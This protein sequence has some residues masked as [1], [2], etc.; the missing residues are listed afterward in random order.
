MAHYKQSATLW[1]ILFAVFTLV[2]SVSSAGLTY[3]TIAIHHK[4]VPG[5]TRLMDAVRAGDAR[6]VSALLKEGVDVNKRNAGGVTALMLA[7]SKG[8]TRIA[9]LLLSAGARPDITDYD[10]TTA[11]DRAAQNNYKQLASMLTARS[12]KV[13]KS[14]HVDGY[15]F[16]DDAIVD[17]SHPEWFKHSFYNLPDDLDEAQANGKQGIML[18]MSTRRCSYCKVFLDRVLSDPDIKRRVQSNYDVIGLEILSDLE[19]V[20]VDG[21]SYRVKEFV[22]RVKAAFTPTLIFYGTDGQLQLKIVGYYPQAKFKRVLDYLEGKNYRKEMLREY[23][24]RT[25]SSKPDP[26]AQMIVDRELFSQAP[27]ILDRRAANAQQ[28]L[29][30]VFDRSNCE[31]C[32][33]LHRQ[34]LSDKSIRKLIGQFEAIQLDISDKE[35]RIITPEGEGLSPMQWYQRLNLSYTPAI[36]FFDEAGQEVLRLDSETLRYRMEGTLQLVLE[37]A[38]ENDAQLQRWRREKAIEAI[39]IDK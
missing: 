39:R 15:D 26:A 10:G 32:E 11:A 3:Q 12:R 14:K 25:E 37:R 6:Q 31:A 1:L 36:V 17:I 21:E 9:E 33:R 22:T 4:S 30:V 24:S 23:L 5:E 28:Q 19:I 8:Q 20:D 29:M 18:F 16:A 2:P 38:Y 35:Q 34:V 13:D 7:A 27:H